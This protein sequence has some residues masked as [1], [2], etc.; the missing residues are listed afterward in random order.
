[1]V[2]IEV[3][4]HDEPVPPDSEAM[5]PTRR[6]RLAAGPV[7]DVDAVLHLLSSPG[8]LPRL[9]PLITR[10][11]V[12]Q[13]RREGS[14]EVTDFTIDERVP[15]LGGLV[16][17]PNRYRGRITRDDAH[18]GVLRLSGWSAPGVRIEIRYDVTPAQLV[19]TLWLSAPWWGEPFVFK[20]AL[21]AHQHT[22]TRVLA[23]PAS[24]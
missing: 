2:S 7:A 14:R 1:M 9:H 18:P 23:P 6:V 17:W 16:K 13:Q 11:E 4:P 21:R 22:L 19:E 24:R 15:L 8:E 3:S 5:S 20:T 10:V 12:Q